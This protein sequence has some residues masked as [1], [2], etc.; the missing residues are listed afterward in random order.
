MVLS[1]FFCVQQILGLVSLAQGQMIFVS[2]N[3][4]GKGDSYDFDFYTKHTCHCFDI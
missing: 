4:L 1:Q 2:G 3:K